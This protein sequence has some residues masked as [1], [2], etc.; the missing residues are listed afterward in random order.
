MCQRASAGRRWPVA[1]ERTHNASLVCWPTN[2]IANANHGVVVVCLSV[3]LSVCGRRWAEQLSRCGTRVVV[4]KSKLSS[5][6]VHR[7]FRCRCCGPS[8]RPISYSSSLLF[9]FVIMVVVC[10][11]VSLCVEAVFQSSS[12][13][14]LQ[15]VRMIRAWMGLTDVVESSKC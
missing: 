7:N 11:R 14:E 5:S 12:K 2:E 4:C 15:G 10:T 9:V 3:C 1:G 6:A 8:T 13:V